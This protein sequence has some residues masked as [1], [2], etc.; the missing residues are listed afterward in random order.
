[1]PEHIQQLCKP[2][3]LEVKAWPARSD[4]SFVSLQTELAVTHVKRPRD[5]TE[6]SKSNFV[7]AQIAGNPWAAHLASP[8]SN[9]KLRI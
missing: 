4:V 2:A 5:P 1:M 7:K 6:G 3:M 8:M 9:R